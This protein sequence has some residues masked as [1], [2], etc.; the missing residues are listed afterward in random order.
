MVNLL[1]ANMKL[2]IF[3]CLMLTYA[4]AGCGEWWS[5]ACIGN[6]DKRYDES[7]S[8]D[9]K[10]QHSIWGDLEGY[11]IG[12]F[13]FMDGDGQPFPTSHYNTAYK[14]GW[15]YQYGQYNGFINVTIKGSRYYQHNYFAYPPA[16]AEFCEQTVPEGKLNV[17]GTG[18]CGV[19]GNAKSFDA[20][21][22]TSHEKDG[23]MHSLEGAGTYK[24]F[25]NIAY[26]I[27]KNTMIYVSSDDKTQFHSQTNV[28]YPTKR[29]RTRTAYGFDYAGIPG[30][31]GGRDNPL[32]Y[33]SLYREYKVSKEE[34]LG[35]IKHHNEKF[36]IPIADRIQGGVLPME[37]SCLKGTTTPAHQGAA[38]KCPTEEDFCAIDP[39]CSVSPFVEPDPSVNGG[40]VGGLCVAIIFVLV[41]VGL[42]IH[43]QQLKKHQ[44]KIRTQMISRIGRGLL[45]QFGNSTMDELAAAFAKIDTNGSGDISKEELGGFLQKDPSQKISNSDLDMMFNMI[46]VDSGGTVSFAEFAALMCDQTT[47]K[48]AATSVFPTDAPTNDA[49]TDAPTDT[50]TDPSTAVET[51]S[52]G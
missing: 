27:D 2:A 16:S 24:D 6:G 26:P 28:F 38:P 25:W 44:L 33:S 8:N 11:W 21:G 51:I 22:T 36:N 15:P 12:N 5:N 50:N 32:Y 42:L 41:S 13:T 52:R 39:K 4:S 48:H 40:A 10:D 30:M 3:S 17:I 1:L 18:T 37:T 45:P 29:H 9:F 14:F 19:N 20:F 35:T 34:W 47:V 31:A 43:A 7:Y 46:D 49:P 23:T